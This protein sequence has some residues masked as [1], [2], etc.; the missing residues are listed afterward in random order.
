MPWIS[1]CS[2]RKRVRETAALTMQ[3]E[4]DKVMPRS[5]DHLPTVGAFISGDSD[6]IGK[7]V[8]RSR[9]LL[10]KSKA[11]QEPPSPT[12]LPHAIAMAI[13]AAYEDYDPSA[14][15]E[16]IAAAKYTDASADLQ[17]IVLHILGRG[18]KP[19]LVKPP[20]EVASDEEW[21]DLVFQ[22]P[23]NQAL[24]LALTP[25]HPRWT[26]LAMFTL[27]LAYLLARDA[28]SWRDRFAALVRFGPFAAVENEIV[29]END[30]VSEDREVRKGKT[31]W[32]V[33]FD[34]LRLNQHEL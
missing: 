24:D 34:V 16:V 25:D 13:A 2:E 11:E 15:F 22:G 14:V 18:P 7:A 20:V 31:R 29:Y 32:H 33:G 23:A 28:K 30:V 3:R 17:R 4:H 6:L 9:E 27:P 1:L 5:Y 19:T 10:P 21:I 8:R 26:T 12:L